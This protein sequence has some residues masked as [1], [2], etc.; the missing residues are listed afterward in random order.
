MLIDVERSQLLI[1]DLQERLLPAI[2]DHERLVANVVWLIGVAQKVGVP[3]GRS[4]STR[5][6]SAAR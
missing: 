6:A 1:I 3:V 4:S 2:H 5:T